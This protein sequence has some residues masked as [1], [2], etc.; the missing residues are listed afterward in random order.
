MHAA[1]VA[2]PLWTFDA[3]SLAPARLCEVTLD[4]RPGIT[5]VLGWSGAGK[6]SLLNVLAGFEKPDAGRVLPPAAKPGES[7]MRLPLAWVPQSGGL[8]PHCTVREHLAIAEAG[9]ASVEALLVALDLREKAKARPH[10]LSQGQQARLSVAR[11]LAMAA[12]VLIMDEPLAHVDPARA[13]KYWQVIREQLAATGASLVFSTHLPEIALGEAERV[14]CLSEGRVLHEG[15]VHELYD[16]PPTPELMTF[17]GPGNWFAPDEAILWLNTSVEQ[18]RCFRPERVSVAPEEGG[19]LIV[20]STR[21]RGSV[22]EVNLRHVASGVVRQFFHRPTGDTMRAG[23]RVRALLLFLCAALFVFTG[24]QRRPGGSEMVAREWQ[25]WVLPPDGATLPT[26]RS[27]AVG[28]AGEVATLDTAGRVLIYDQS[29]HVRRQW[30]MLE[31]KVG[32]PEGIVI[33]K[34]GRVVVCDTHY[35]RIVWFDGDGNWL[36]NIGAHGTKDGEFI[37]PVGICLDAEEN[38]YVCEYGGN[39]RIQKFS[40]E[41]Q[42]LTSFGSFG[43]GPGQFQRP[44]GLTWKDGKVYVADAINNR[45]TIFSDAGKYL[46]VLGGE[47]KPLA[48]N[49][50]Y[51]I[52]TGSDGNFYI[53]E[54]GAGRLSRV[55]PEGRVL[56]Q[57]GHS[58][59][60]EGEFGTP[61]ALVVDPQM[62]IFVA[63]TKN[64]RLVALKL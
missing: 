44:S 39:D 60:G 50:P 53:V 11:A 17:L 32:K 56:G 25:T 2:D 64:R 59:T 52:A 22:A 38:L 30:Q 47:E 15:P 58:G 46:G 21:F 16:D 40:R 54:Y 43:T 7:T 8:W 28:H 20:E 1:M 9:A 23:T 42:W 6:T 31:V 45:V 19:A 35:H 37:Y 41:G 51:D 49:L 24:C 27:V 34:D 4:I 5:A 61:W 18:P 13:G 3:V 14:I 63:D 55:S 48:L 57:L 12:R 36:K 62:R 26:P 29:G 33:L 10:E